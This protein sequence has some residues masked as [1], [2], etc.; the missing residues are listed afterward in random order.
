MLF[1]F[2]VCFL[3]Q[4]Q[5]ES[6][7]FC[8]CFFLYCIISQVKSV[9]V[10]ATKVMLAWRGEINKDGG[11]GIGPMLRGKWHHLTLPRR[12]GRSV[13]AGEDFD[14]FWV[15]TKKKKKKN[16]D[17]FLWDTACAG[18]TCRTG[19]WAALAVQQSVWPPSLACVHVVHAHALLTAD[20]A[21]PVEDAVALLFA[22]LSPGV[23]AA[24][25]AQQVAALDAVRRHVAG[26]VT[27]PKGAG[28]RVGLAEV[29]R[30][31]VVDQVAL[32]GVLEEVVLDPQ[33]LHPAP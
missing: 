21:A 11:E 19:G 16:D 9:T 14:R 8:F 29:R 7:S 26:S 13:G 18:G 25:A 20:V 33:S 6:E 15:S 2:F 24:A 23:V 28:L 17:L 32:G 12:V 10:H 5:R 3:N 30:A 1:F 27:R 4:K 31:L 22:L